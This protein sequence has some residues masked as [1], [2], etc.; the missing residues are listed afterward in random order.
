[1]RVSEHYGLSLS[2]GELD[3]VDVEIRGD[4]PLFLDPAALRQMRGEWAHECIALIQDFFQ[5]VIDAIR[6]GHKAHAIELISGLCEPNETR[7]GLSSGVPRG[8]ALGPGS[9]EITWDALQRSEATRTGLLMHLED[10]ALLVRGVGL[11]SSRTSLPT[12]CARHS[13][14][15]RRIWRV[16]TGFVSRPGWLPARSGIPAGADGRKAGSCQ[17]LFRIG[18]Q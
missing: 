13:S 17:C 6:S 3:F 15:T 16:T 12:S 14:R 11:T 18:I 10:T 8:R 9:A 7:L 5:T 4:T 1:M 2:Q